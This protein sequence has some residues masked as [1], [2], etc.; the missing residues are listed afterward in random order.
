MCN[1]VLKWKR[2]HGSR[3]PHR[4]RMT[5]EEVERAIARGKM[6]AM[7]E[8]EDYRNMILKR[9]G[10]IPDWVPSRIRR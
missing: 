7:N 10:C 9:Y 4:P 1:A 8:D 5:P 6:L 3:K 2:C